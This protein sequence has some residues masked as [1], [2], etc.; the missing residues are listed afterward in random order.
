MAGRRA[1]LAGLMAGGVAP[2]MSWADLGAVS[3]LSAGR[4]ADGTHVLCGLSAAGAIV[5]Q[6]DLPARGHA[7]AAHPDRA[8][9]VGF[10]RRPGMFA[11]VLDCG[12][13]DVLHRLEAPA[14]R[15]FYGHGVF[16]DDGA[17][18]FTTENDYDAARGIVGVWDVAAGYR[19][20][21]EFASGGVGPHGIKRTP[22]G[23]LVVANGGIETHP[24]AGRAK[25]NLPDMRPNLTYLS[26][27]G[28]VIEQV[29]LP[30]ELHRNSIRHLAVAA[31]GTVGFAMQWQ[32]DAAARVPLLGRHRLGGAVALA[33]AGAFREMRGYLGS[34]AMVGRQIAVTSPRG[35]LVQIHDSARLA[36][37]SE[38]AHEDVCGI[39]PRGGGFLATTG[40]GHVLRPGGAPLA[41]HRVQWDNHL[42]PL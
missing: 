33:E 28:A 32:G 14:G 5:F 40:T 21:G 6:R 12:R 20:L 23:H 22:R 18:L 15:H 38:A 24:D 4:R 3:Y 11:L 9:A 26:L 16:S 31:D 35:H 27:E 34:I 1:F 2:R 8:E 39:A 25:L 29:E 42:I 19:R 37:V 30:P 36:K 7:A 41:R 10:A 17:R 13:G